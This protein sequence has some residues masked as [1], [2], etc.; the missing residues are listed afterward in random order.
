MTKMLNNNKITLSVCTTDESGEGEFSV[1]GLGVTSV[2]LSGSVVQSSW[3][4]AGDS[5]SPS[6]VY[7]LPQKAKEYKSDVGPVN[8]YVYMSIKLKSV[9]LL[10]S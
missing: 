2:T 5:V 10:N 1:S 3:S 9:N 7:T 8:L 6:V 4:T